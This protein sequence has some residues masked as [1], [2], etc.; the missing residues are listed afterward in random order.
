MHIRTDD[1]HTPDVQGLILEHLQEM[2][3]TSPQESVH[4]LG[5]DQLRADGVTLWTVRQDDGELL[6]CGAL[7]RLDSRHGEIKAMR[8]AVVA[9]GRG[10]AGALLEHLIGHARGHGLRRLSLETGTQGHFAPARR[11]YAR[12]GFTEC[13]PFGEYT[14]DPHS[15]FMTLPL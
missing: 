5:L 14:E 7:K 12:H 3:A 1:P 15:V 13:P 6:G 11:L 10:V 9:R 2:H 8:T 4:A